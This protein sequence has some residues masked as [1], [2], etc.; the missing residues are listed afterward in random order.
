MRRFLHAL[1]AFRAEKDIPDRF[2]DQLERL[3]G[4]E[5][6]MAGGARH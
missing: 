6:S 5:N 2:R 1:P 4:L 3:D